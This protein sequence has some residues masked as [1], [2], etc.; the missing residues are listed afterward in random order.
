MCVCVVCVCACVFL[1]CILFVVV[2]AAV[3]IDNYHDGGF[4]CSSTKSPDMSHLGVSPPPSPPSRAN[5][6]VAN[7]LPRSSGCAH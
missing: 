3:F 2:S 6:D 1:F 7:E 4:L 5:P